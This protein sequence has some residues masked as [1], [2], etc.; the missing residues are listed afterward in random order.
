MRTASFSEALRQQDLQLAQSLINYTMGHGH[1]RSQPADSMTSEP[2][3]SSELLYQSDVMAEV[4][5]LIRLVAPTDET[6]LITGESGTGKEVIAREIHRRSSRS[7]APFVIVD[8]GAVVSTLIERE[9]FGHVKGAFTGATSSSPGKLREAD[10]GTLLL[11]EIGELPLD[12]QV[13]LL[14]VV[15]DK[16]FTAVGSTKVETADTRIIAATNVDLDS[17]I[18][19][20]RFR[21]DLYYRLNVFNVHSPPLRY[22]DGDILFLAQ[23]FLERCSAQYGRS[24]AG[25]TAA[26]EEVMLRYRWPGNIR[27]LRN[28]LIRAVILCQGDR[29]DVS[30]LDL[31]R[32]SDRLR[33]DAQRREDVGSSSIREA[34]ENLAEI[35]SALREA[36]AELIRRCL[37]TARLVPL[38]QWL[39]RELIL[40]ALELHGQINLQAAE[41]LGIPES[42]LRRKLSRYRADPAERPPELQ[43]QWQAALAILPAW[44]RVARREGF[45][46]MRHMQNLLLSEID[47]I[48]RNQ[49]E[50]ASLVG[51][52]P[53]T[54]RRQLSQLANW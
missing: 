54:Y 34:A 36:L 52:S 17:E 22:R 41:A 7:R 18:K 5:E 43:A 23:H 19:Q 27:E 47:S 33:V 48:A 6:V 44:I 30:E 4:M 10:G 50:G 28:K 32:E 11:D 38:S 39:E 31:R 1:G 21:E 49:S 9:L 26:A 20:G 24:I 8:C 2:T 25:F 12:V 13:K 45:N 14:R 46:P 29:I 3:P 53:P 16:Q 40:A 35:E 15:Q 51:V 42:T 37:E